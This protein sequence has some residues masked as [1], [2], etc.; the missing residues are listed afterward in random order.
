MSALGLGFVPPQVLAPEHRQYLGAHAIPDHVIDASGVYSLGTE[1][2]FPWRDG[3][4]VTV[5]RR[6]WPGKSG[7]YYWD[8]GQPL[9]FWVH[10]DPGPDA[11]V[12]LVEG[13]KQSLAVHAWAPPEYAVMGMV[14]CEGASRCKLRRFSGRKVVV[15][16]D[17]DAASNANVY[18]AGKTLRERLDFYTQQV[19][20]TYLPARGD[21]GIDDVLG[22][23]FDPEERPAFIEHLISKAGAQPATKAPTARGSGK[24]HDE[25]PPGVGDRVAV[26]VNGDRR[27]VVNTIASTLAERLGG[28]ELFSFG[29]LVTRLRGHETQPLDRDVFHS[30]LLDHVACFHRTEGKGPVQ[31]AH[32]WPDGQSTGAVLSRAELFPLLNRV[33]RTPFVRPDGSVCSA[34]GYDALTGT[35]LFPG[36]LD[37]LTVD[38]NPD[39]ELVKRCAGY[40]MGE[41]LGDMPFE[42]PADRANCLAMILTPFVRGLVPLMPMAII[43]G[44][45]MGVGKNL[46]ADV[47]WLMAN[48]EE[49]PTMAMPRDEDEMRKQITSVFLGGADAFVFDEAH[50]IDSAQLA[51]ALTSKIY[52]DRILGV[53][54]QGKFPNTAVWMAMGNQ[55]QVNGDMSRRVF[56]VKLTPG[57]NGGNTYDNERK[58]RHEHLDVW[59][60]EN[61]ATLVRAALTVIR[62][63]VTGGSPRFD[64]GWSMG[65]FEAWDRVLGGITAYAGYPDFLAHERAR[66]SESD[67]SLHYWVQHLM[68]LE[69]EM[70]LDKPFTTAMVKEAAALAPQT[71][72][73][74]G[75]PELTNPVTEGYTRKLGQAYGRKKNVPMEG[76]LKL[77]DAGMGHNNTRRWMVTRPS[78]KSPSAS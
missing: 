66:R 32:A 7:E 54:R 16:L 27:E 57:G 68:W 74:E 36:E 2:V 58:Y 25:G 49:A 5:Q 46:L 43:D 75:P 69:R 3:D 20:F 12:L 76:G 13:T 67:Y 21:T 59:T 45:H 56:R 44:L 35:F 4:T 73:Y 61:R 47:M 53:S 71:N 1:I 40:L 38:E 14:G 8:A 34:S 77:V 18:N 41:W 24:A 39:Q 72:Q 30:T 28:T 6:P 48:G 22:R 33:T 37:G 29:G 60:K 62:G 23:E 70:G 11:P 63:W 78:D 42:T 9:H 31:Y 65:S 26:M 15:I 19:S 50:T 64:R 10:R 51:R 17:A 55:V 52:T